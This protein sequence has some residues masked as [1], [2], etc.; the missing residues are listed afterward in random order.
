MNS[1]KEG[2]HS[3]SRAP[4]YLLVDS[5]FHQPNKNKKVFIHTDNESLAYLFNNKTSKD[6]NVMK[7]IRPML[8]PLMK[9]I[10]NLK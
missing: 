1:C 8:L 5:Y 3:R 9:L 7:L 4:P 6:A 2:Y 10:V